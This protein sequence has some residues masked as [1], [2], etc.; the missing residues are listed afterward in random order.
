MSIL[1]YGF[2]NRY[3]LLSVLWVTDRNQGLCEG[4]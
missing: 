2:G 3:L 4:S 1:R